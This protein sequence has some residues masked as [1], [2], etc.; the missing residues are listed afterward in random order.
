MRPAAFVWRAIPVSY[1]HLDV[2]KRQTFCA[3]HPDMKYI[4]VCYL[5][6]KA[7]IT[8]TCHVCLDEN[9]YPYPGIV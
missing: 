2:Y 4:S 7:D 5:D 8:L 6:K 3:L 9:L 1:T